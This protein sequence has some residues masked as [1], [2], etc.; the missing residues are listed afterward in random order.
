MEST[1]SKQ[2]SSLDD[3]PSSSK[4]H[5]AKFNYVEEPID[6]DEYEC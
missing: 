3:I 5:N 4:S 2:E 6:D 1:T